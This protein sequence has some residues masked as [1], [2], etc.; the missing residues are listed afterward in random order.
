MTAFVNTNFEV[1]V[2]SVDIAGFATSATLDAQYEEIDITNLASNGWR[3]KITGLGTHTWTVEGFQSLTSVD[4]SFPGTSLGLNTITIAPQN[5]GATIGDAAYFGQARTVSRTPLAGAV[6]DVAGFTLNWAGTGQLARGQ[7]LHPLAARTATGNGTV[8]T[9]T[10][11]AAGQFL[12]ASFHV[13][14]VTGS[15]SITFSLATDDAVGFA[16]PTTRLTSAAM[17]AVGGQFVSVAGPFAG[18]THIR[19]TW[20]ISGFTSVSFVIAAGLSNTPA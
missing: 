7:I 8:T 5:G 18:E 6:G 12:C 13:T 14:S 1:L 10:T 16:S 4:P 3:Q 11:P 9:F 17:T 2:D 19:P 20:T 15:G